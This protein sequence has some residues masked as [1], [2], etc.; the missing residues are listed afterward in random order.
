MAAGG[1]PATA[2]PNTSP[3]SEAA[4]PAELT[5]EKIGPADCVEIPAGRYYLSDLCYALPDPIYDEIWGKQFNYNHGAY[6]RSDGAMF[7]VDHTAYGDGGYR[8]S[9]GETYGVDAGV[10]ALT[11]AAL[12]DKPYGGRWYELKTPGTFSASD[13]VFELMGGG[14]Y[15]RINTAGGEDEDEDEDDY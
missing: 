14:V 6:R 12:T 8:G 11:S 2:T 3:A 5:W 15:V 13:G 10:I 7:I 1:A 9:D 4:E